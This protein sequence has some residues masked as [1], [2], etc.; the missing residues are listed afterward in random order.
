[1]TTPTGLTDAERAAV[2]DG[3]PFPTRPEEWRVVL[4]NVE[5]IVAARI[6]ALTTDFQALADQWN[7]VP[8]YTPSDYDQGRVDQRHAMTMQLLE[9]LPAGATR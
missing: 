1:M 3:F 2:L 8:D 6:E 5:R 4:R 7:E 9:L